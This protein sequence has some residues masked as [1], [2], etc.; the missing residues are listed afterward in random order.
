[1]NSAGHL[2]EVAR[3]FFL[4]GLIVPVKNR[5]PRFPQFGD[6]GSSLVE[7]ALLL[8]LIATVCLGALAALGG[9]NGDGIDRSASLINSASVN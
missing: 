8:A 4:K 1:M 2:S 9:Q 7:Y 5:S 3:R 6:R